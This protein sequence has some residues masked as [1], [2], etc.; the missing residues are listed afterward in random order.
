[1]SKDFAMDKQAKGEDKKFT[2]WDT[3]AV[4][5]Y[6][7]FVEASLEP[8]QEDFFSKKLVNTIVATLISLYNDWQKK[9]IDWE[10]DNEGK[11]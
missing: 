2:P 3:V 10:V 11:R 5:H 4:E 7:S 6:I 8:S 1:M 9:H